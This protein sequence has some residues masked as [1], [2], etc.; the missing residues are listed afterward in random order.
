MTKPLRRDAEINRQRILKA[1]QEVFAAR[2]VDVML[3]DIAHHAGLG[4]GTVYRRF[5]T[6]EDLVE[7]LFD[8]RLE[9]IVGWAEDGLRH[10][11]PWTGLTEFVE[12]AT[13]AMA[14]DRGLRDIA[15]SRA[16]GRRRV[17]EIREMLAPRVEALV[18]RCQ[19]AGVVRADAAG[20]DLVLTQFMVAA[21][22]EYAEPIAPGLWRRYLTLLLDGLRFGT[23]PLP[24]PPPEVENMD[25]I[26]ENWRPPRRPSAD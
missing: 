23:T 11:D 15:F 13:A 18:T 20:V 9:E 17:A 24:V 26:A 4:V 5:P 1:A 7:A 12:R 14:A 16:Y 6:R 19:E 25:R 22:L 8:T 2:G 10:A 21:L 3:D